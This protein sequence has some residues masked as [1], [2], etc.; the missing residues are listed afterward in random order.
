VEIGHL[1]YSGRSEERERD[2]GLPLLRVAVERSVEGEGLTYLS[3]WEDV[4]IGEQVT[5]PLGKS[6]ATGVVIARGGNELL[7][8]L[9]RERVR[10][11]L[12]RTGVAMAPDL[13]ELGRWIAAYYLTPLGMVLAS[14]VPGAVKRRTGRRTIELIGRGPQEAEPA[15]LAGTKLTPSV[16]AAWERIVASDADA[17]PMEPRLLAASI[18]T[19]LA[20]INRLVA[21]GLLVRSEREEVRSRGFEPVHRTDSTPDTRPNLLAEQAA[22]IDGIGETLGAFSV[23]ML[24]GITGSGKTEVY[25]RLIDRVLERG[26]TSLVLV[27]EISLTPQTSRRFEARFGGKVAVLH[28]GLSASQRNHQWDLAA[29]GVARVVVGARSA[30]FAP[31]ANLGLIV[32][33]EEHDGSY[34]QDTLPRYH[35]RDVAIKRAQMAS[36]PVVLGSATP[37]LESWANATGPRAK[38]RLW[39][40]TQR[41]G[42]GKLPTVKVV[43]LASEQPWGSAKASAGG[44]GRGPLMIGATLRGALGRTLREGGQAILLLNRRGFATFMHCPSCKWILSCDECDAAMVLHRGSDLPRGQVVRCHHCLAER[45]VPKV[46]ELCGNAVVGLG[47]GTQRVEEELNHIL[48]EDLPDADGALVRLDAD[49]VRSVRE[50]HGALERFGSGE[51]RVLLGTQMIA[52]GLDYPNVRLVGVIS[53][54]TALNLPDFRSMERTYQLVSQVA[55]RAGRGEHP[56]LVIVQTFSPTTPAIRL[57]AAH[58]FEGFAAMELRT[59][60]RACLPPAWRM[61]RIVV[62]DRDHPKGAER[63]RRLGEIL[64]D[65]AENQGGAE[66]VRIDGPAPSAVARVEGWHRWDLLIRAS[67]AGV[68]QRVLGAARAEGGL[69]SDAHT[70]VDVDPVSVM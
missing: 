68:V 32:V 54:D 12:D 61:A 30:A 28:S 51:A 63:A 2:S 15:I 35:G 50:L 5:V 36:C 40:L 6:R 38:Y 59:R 64:R 43:D 65:A 11:I 10:R 39:K 1:P 9:D 14:M 23:H 70:A 3:P 20:P 42:G 16:R 18:G 19:T 44:N 45:L 46:C 17:G 41:A 62:R 25:L 29:S 60:E 33:D 57:A 27:P 31:L 56:G 66:R 67:S 58:D 37:S 49:T 13:V 69:V 55:G 7:D 22:A 47:V 24:F 34:K 53:A 21:A 8:G 52:K 26:D 48:T 4:R